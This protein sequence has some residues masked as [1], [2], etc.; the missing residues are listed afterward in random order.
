MTFEQAAEIEANTPITAGEALAREFRISSRQTD[1]KP[2]GTRESLK[3]CAN[4]LDMYAPEIFPANDKGQVD[5]GRAMMESVVDE[6]T[7]FLNGNNIQ[8]LEAE[9]KRLLERVRELER[10]ERIADTIADAA[11][12]GA[13]NNLDRAIGLESQLAAANERVAELERLGA[14]DQRD[15][16]IESQ[17]RAD[18]AEAQLAAANERIAGLEKLGIEGPRRILEAK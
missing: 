1:G 5:F 12:G 13:M 4:M 7:A 9:N 6:I 3:R 8:A 15:A 17:K 2:E 10:R 16:A 14:F 11:T 18:A